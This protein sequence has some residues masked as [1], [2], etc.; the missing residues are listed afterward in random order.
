MS[1]YAYKRDASRGVLSAAPLRRL[2]CS[3]RLTAQ[4]LRHGA[5]TPVLG[6]LFDP[7]LAFLQHRQFK[8]R[9]LLAQNLRLDQ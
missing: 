8:P 5:L 1:I 9:Q 7:A 2:A 4:R 3:V 6:P